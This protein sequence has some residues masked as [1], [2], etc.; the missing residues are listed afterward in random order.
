MY[1]STLLLWYFFITATIGFFEWVMLIISS[2]F[3]FYVHR[4]FENYP[5]LL[6]TAITPF[7][8]IWVFFLPPSTLGN[9]ILYCIFIGG[10]GTLLGRIFRTQ[11]MYDEYI[12]QTV[13][14]GALLASTGYYFIIAGFEGVL[15]I[16]SILLMFSGILF[17]SFLQIRKK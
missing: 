11:Y 7:I 3:N 8:L 9:Y 10:G 13:T 14:I 6:F 5:S 2:F 17:I 12:F 4:R 1:F 16:S 15:Q